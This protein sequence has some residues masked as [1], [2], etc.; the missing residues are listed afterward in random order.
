MPKGKQ[1]NSGRPRI[2]TDQELKELAL[3]VKNRLGHVHLTYSLLEKETSIG[4]NTWKRRLEKTI[5]ELNKPIYRTIGVNED[6]E[7]YFPNIEQIFEIYKGNTTKIINTLHEFETMFIKLYEELHILKKDEQKVIHIKQ[8]AAEKDSQIK[9]LKI[10]VEHYKNLYD[11]LTISSSFPHLQEK[12]RLKDNLLD[13]NANIDK[14]SSLTNF[15]TLFNTS[16]NVSKDPIEL[17][18]NSDLEEPINKLQEMFPNFFNE[19]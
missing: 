15:K 2:F 11:Q 17:S 19:K 18:E 9:K 13:F 6:D 7:V 12:T 1:R 4:R 16:K 14:N 8:I 10:Q 5:A 3:E